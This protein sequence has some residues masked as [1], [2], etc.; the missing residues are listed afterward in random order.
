MKVLSSANLI[1][2]KN[3]IIIPNGFLRINRR[4]KCIVN[5]AKEPIIP[6]DNAE[7]KTNIVRNL[8]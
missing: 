5:I 4:A 2:A 1:E 3:G 7:I 6:P 8:Q